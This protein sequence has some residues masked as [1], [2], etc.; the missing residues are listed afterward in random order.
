MTKKMFENDSITVLIEPVRQ[1]ICVFWVIRSR[2]TR[3]RVNIYEIGAKVWT[4][5]PEEE[6]LIG[7][8]SVLKTTLTHIGGWLGGVLDWVV[9]VTLGTFPRRRVDRG[10][11]RL[12]SPFLQ[13][14]K[15]PP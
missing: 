4:M 9:V 12:S 8:L 3:R 14:N 11:G 1:E 7:K 15:S 6:V 13:P 2:L 5:V 10:P